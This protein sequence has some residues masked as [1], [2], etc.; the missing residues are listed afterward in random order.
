MRNSRPT[1]RMVH[2]T[3]PINSSGAKAGHDPAGT[4]LDRCRVQIRLNRRRLW[5]WH[6]WLGDALARDAGADC[7]V[8]LV[9]GPPLPGA[10]ALLLS[11]ERLIYGLPGEHACDRLDQTAF[12]AALTG[13]AGSP[14]P[15]LVLD[16]S[17]I[18]PRNGLAPLLR[19]TYDGDPGE[20]ALIAALLE[21]K[22]P[23]LAIGD[24]A[25]RAWVAHP[26]VEDR[27]V[28]TRALDNAFSTALRLC[29]K[30][31]IGFKAGA[32]AHGSS[33]PQDRPDLPPWRPLSFA[34][35]T[36]VARARSRL[37]RLCRR[38]PAWF[39]GWRWAD[40]ERMQV[41]HRLPDDG[42]I[43]L[44]DDGRRYYADPFVIE[45]DGI[46]HLLVEE[47]DY[48]LGRAVISTT[49]VPRHGVPQTPRV[50]LER[51]YHLSYPFVFRHDGQIWMIPESS[52]ARTVELYRADPFPD[53]WVLESVLLRDVSAGDATIVRHDGRWWMF[54]GTS[55]WQSSS[56]DA[57]S[58]FHAPDLFGPWAPHPRNPVLIDARS[59]RPAGAH[60]FPHGGALW[61]PAQDCSGGYGSALSLCRID[62]LDPDDYRQSQQAVIRSGPAWPGRGLHTLNWASGLEVIDGIS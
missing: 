30:A 36:V 41:T 17:G 33:A 26:A 25:A 60:F 23:N 49:V 28:L 8:V 52:A 54:A 4:G 61:R 20:D 45:A 21:G 29:L 16:L 13:A 27:K 18:S 40:D 14:P 56:W 59:A 51:P 19:L 57:L 50:V 10:V 38:A 55:A 43:R 6:R 42:F 47:Y 1:S 44:P 37:T 62:R 48:A 34:A 22:L 35:Q 3:S 12:S 32:L 31:T 39:V 11:F 9:D 2:D 24:P 58:L 46:H 5:R 15:D 53:R 7:E